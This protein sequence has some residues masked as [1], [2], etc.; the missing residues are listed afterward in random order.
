MLDAIPG[1]MLVNLMPHQD[2]RGAY[3]ELYRD[4]WALEVRPSQ[5]NVN[6]SN[7]G[8]MRGVQA[9]KRR[10]DYT[11]MLSGSMILALHDTR[12]SSPMF[13]KTLMAEFHKHDGLA[14]I[15]PPR[16]AHGLYYLEDSVTLIGFT[17]AWDPSDDFRCHHTSPELSMKW[18][19]P[20]KCIS[21]SDGAAQS[22][23]AFL[24]ALGDA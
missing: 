2:D 8:T 21:D 4:D 1:V 15:I 16:V 17:D 7:A 10:Y 6:H 22:Y 13:G 9:H 11:A 3:T 12:R 24:A 20:V 5:W 19:G 14:I 23:Q 18:P